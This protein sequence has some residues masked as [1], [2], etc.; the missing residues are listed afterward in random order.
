MNDSNKLS[1]VNIIEKNIVMRNKCACI[2]RLAE[3]GYVIILNLKQKIS[4]FKSNDGMRKYLRNYKD[5]RKIVGSGMFAF[6]YL[7][8]HLLL[9]AINCK[10]HT[11]PYI[12]SFL[13]WL[14]MKFQMLPNIWL[15]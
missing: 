5:S 12:L 11:E 14:G 1:D 9:I 15:N 2:T 8:C 3:F 7:N 13:K 10:R 6:L 4:V